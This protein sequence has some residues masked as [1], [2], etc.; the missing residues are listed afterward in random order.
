M[1]RIIRLRQVCDHPFLIDG[2]Q[3]LGSHEDASSKIEEVMRILKERKPGQKTVVFTHFAEVIPFITSVLRPKFG[4]TTYDGNMTSEKR[5]TALKEIEGDSCTVIIVSI[6]AGGVG[7]DLT[8][9]NT[10]IL[11]EPWWNPFAEEQAISRSYRSGQ[12]LPVDVFRLVVEGSIEEESIKKTQI[13][14]RE[15][16]KDI[17]GPCP[18]L[19]RST[20]KAWLAGP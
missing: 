10:V 3:P 13:D 19:E 9:C 2:K 4:V 14:K 18:P 20:C 8:A 11:F 6:K 12:K 1:V 17:S 5:R 16:M 7:I 15:M